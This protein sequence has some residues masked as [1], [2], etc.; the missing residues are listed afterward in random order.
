M[1][2]GRPRGATN[3]GSTRGCSGRLRWRRSQRGPLPELGRI[4]RADGSISLRW[5]DRADGGRTNGQRRGWKQR[6]A[7]G[8]L[9]GS[10]P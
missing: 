6:L 3:P 5:P 4:G 10:S 8:P 9:K 7:N 2:C 1:A